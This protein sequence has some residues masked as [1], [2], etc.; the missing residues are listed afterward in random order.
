MRHS[1][2]PAVTAEQG[3]LSSQDN[4][5]HT[6]VATPSTVFLAPVY[7]NPTGETH[8][9]ELVG[10]QHADL[11]QLEELTQSTPGMSTAIYGDPPRRSDV[12]NNIT[13]IDGSL[14]STVMIESEKSLISNQGVGSVGATQEAILPRNTS[15]SP[16]T[17][18]VRPPCET[19]RV[20]VRSSFK[21]A[22]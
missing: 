1:P 5:D 12:F 16:Q 10:Q 13:E 11:S 18:M 4:A 8:Q 3:L 22:S 17:S 19:F 9:Q 6:A 21:P 2:P 20:E 15:I 7:P 14:D